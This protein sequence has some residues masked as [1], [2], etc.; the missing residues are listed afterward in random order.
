MSKQP[1]QALI[2]IGLLL[3]AIGAIALFTIA[4][5]WAATGIGTDHSGTRRGVLS[6]M[7]LLGGLILMFVGSLGAAIRRSSS[8]SRSAPR[9]VR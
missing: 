8:P 3:A 9:S 5:G 7:L 1:Y 2:M 6:V 4:G